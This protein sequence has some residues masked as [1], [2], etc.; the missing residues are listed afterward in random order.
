MKVQAALLARYAEVDSNGGLL[1]ITGGG[2]D[3]FGSPRLPVDIS[4][5]FVLQLTFDEAEAGT[6]HRL[7][8]FVRDPD[9]AQVGKT[10]DVAFVPRLGELHPPGWRG[11]FSITGGLELHV[12]R[13]GPHSVAIQIDGRESADLPFLMIHD[14]S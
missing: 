8:V 12:E 2:L 3:I 6:E 13:E 5:A 9:L 14:K 4:V 7:T 1:N 11:H 10:V